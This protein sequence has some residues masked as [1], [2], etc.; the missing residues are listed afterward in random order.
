MMARKS[1]IEAAIAVEEKKLK[2]MENPRSQLYRVSKAQ[3]VHEGKNSNTFRNEMI[4]MC[5]STLD[6]LYEKL[7]EVEALSD[8]YTD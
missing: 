7:R 3:A 4:D 8:D 1:T 5:N 6:F 2:D